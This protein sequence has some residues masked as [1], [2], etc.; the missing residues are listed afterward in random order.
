MSQNGS[1]YAKAVIPATMTAG[2]LVRAA[3][4]VRLARAGDPR[5]S[6]REQDGIARLYRRTSRSVLPS[7]HER[8]ARHERHHRPRD[9]HGEA[10]PLGGKPAPVI[11]GFTGDQRF[12]ISWAQFWCHEFRPEFIRNQLATDPNSPA[13]VRA[14]GTVR[15]V[16]AW[17]EAFNVKP[18]DKLYVAPEN[19]VR[20]W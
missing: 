12:F 10:G 18:G 6:R 15:N 20:I 14:S 13:I 3:H 19:R 1:W 4:E 16:D 9:A 11:E 5:D 7:V 2:S 17:Y 8:S